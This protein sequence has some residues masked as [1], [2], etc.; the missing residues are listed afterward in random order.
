MI[1]VLIADDNQ[2]KIKNLRKVISEISTDI[3]LDT[4]TNVIFAKRMITENHY[5]LLVLDLAL[6]MRDGDDPLPINGINFLADINRGSGKLKRPFHIIGFS[7]FDEHITN[8]KEQFETELW[9][10][11]KYDETNTSWRNQISTK[12]QYLIKSKSDLSSYNS[13][14]YDFDLAIITALRN[15]ELN[16]ILKLEADW[17]TLKLDKDSTEY[18]VGVFTKEDKR[19]KVVAASAPQMGMVAAAVLT[20][21]LLTNFRPKYIVMTGIAGGVKGIGNFGDILISD[22]AF[23][24]GSGKIKT[25]EQGEQEFS[26]DFRSINLNADLKESL[27]SCKG[28]REFLNEIKSKWVLNNMSSELNIHVGPLASGA[29]V[30]ENQKALDQ[31]KIHSRKLIG[32]D[33]ETY[34]VFYA[35]ENFIKPKPIAALSIKSISDFG[36]KEKNDDYQPYASYTSA[37]FLY[38]FALNKMDFDI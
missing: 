16:S 9:S 18:H 25:S 26:P 33:M 36:D 10:L 34:G 7:A 35:A 2:N 11:I 20:T 30:L 27:L 24:S 37:S 5:D 17:K 38:Y 1:S 4:T 28:S 32:I 15:P 21:K 19:I 6:P 22:I 13:K 3:N 12:I 23:D 31:I 29:S 8:F 14:Q